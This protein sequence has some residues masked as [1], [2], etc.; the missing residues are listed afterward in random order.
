[1][2]INLDNYKVPNSPLSTPDTLNNVLNDCRKYDINV[3]NQEEI[4]EI[5]NQYQIQIFNRTAFLCENILCVLDNHSTGDH[6]DCY[7]LNLDT[8]ENL[9]FFNIDFWFSNTYCFNPHYHIPGPWDNKLDQL[10]T[11]WKKRILNKK[12]EQAENV[13]LAFI[14]QQLAE[15][16][17]IESFKKLF[18]SDTTE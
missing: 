6:V 14:Q 2:K 13:R 12:Y 5:E 17:A 15:K 18:S 1:M 7:V 8:K 9:L 3:L 4:G 11:S 10:Q 16:V